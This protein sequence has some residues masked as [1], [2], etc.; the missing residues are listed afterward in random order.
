VPGEN[1]ENEE[2]G[3]EDNQVDGNGSGEN[4]EGTEE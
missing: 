3:G 1:E 2:E 4:E